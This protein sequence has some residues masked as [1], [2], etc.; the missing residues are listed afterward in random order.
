MITANYDDDDYDHFE[1]DKFVNPFFAP[2]VSS[3]QFSPGW[4][5]VGPDESFGD[6]TLWQ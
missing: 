3:F 6:E 5:L 1:F 4:A 2:H